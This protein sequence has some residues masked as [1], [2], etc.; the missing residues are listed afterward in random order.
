MRAEQGKREY[1]NSKNHCCYKIL[2]L[3]VAI[4]EVFILVGEGT[5]VI[6]LWM[7][8]KQV[9]DYKDNFEAVAHFIHHFHLY[10]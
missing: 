10:S 2:S 5:L 8:S 3:E 4:R 1:Y 9:Q 7:C 6:L